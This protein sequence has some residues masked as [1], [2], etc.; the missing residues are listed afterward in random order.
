MNQ[1]DTNFLKFYNKIYQ[2]FFW[3]DP[4]GAKPRGWKELK[5]VIKQHVKKKSEIVKDGWKPSTKAVTE[6]QNELGLKLLPGKVHQKWFRDP[7]TGLHSNDAE[8][9]ISKLKGWM[10]KRYGSIRGRAGPEDEVDHNLASKVD[11]Y[12]F[13][14]NIGSSMDNVMEALHYANG[15]KHRARDI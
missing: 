15:G 2:K 3:G 7:T 11:E 13:L 9:E 10:R 6:L 14:N 4:R 12:M 8:S 5:K 1:N